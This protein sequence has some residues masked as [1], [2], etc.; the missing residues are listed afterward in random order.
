MQFRAMI[1][2][3]ITAGSYLK[4]MDNSRMA[5]SGPRVGRYL[6]YGLLDPRNACLCYVG[7][8]HKR[9]ELRLAEHVH[10]AMNGS[11]RPV[12]VWIRELILEGVSPEVFVLERVKP[13][14]SW[15]EAERKAI[16]DW[17]TWRSDN[18]PYVHPPQTRKSSEVRIEKVCLLNVS[19][20]G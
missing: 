10:D 6:I 20:G 3:G 12:H 7:K 14:E 5:R 16:D 1:A 17:R 15:Q 18:L 11:Q 19:S 8:T 13:E 9:R 4:L 2:L